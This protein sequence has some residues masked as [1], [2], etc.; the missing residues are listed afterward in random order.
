MCR[1]EYRVVSTVGSEACGLGGFMEYDEALKLPLPYTEQAIVSV[2]DYLA[3]K[4]GIEDG[5]DQKDN[6]STGRGR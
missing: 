4:L 1:S 6:G 3:G 5:E 2:R